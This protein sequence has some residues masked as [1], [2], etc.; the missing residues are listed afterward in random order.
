[1]NKQNEK[2]ILFENKNN[3][4]KQILNFL[5]NTFNCKEYDEVILDNF[6]KNKAYFILKVSGCSVSITDE[7]SRM[8]NS[9]SYND[10]NKIEIKEFKD[11]KTLTIYLKEYS[12][13]SI[14]YL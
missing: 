4:Y 2:I 14:S 13:N 6:L 10:I 8:Y 3:D 9:M 5:Q 12:F 7:E 11:H 1:M